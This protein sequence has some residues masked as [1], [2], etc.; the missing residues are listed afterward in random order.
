MGFL[1]VKTGSNLLGIES[2]VAWA[3]IG[4]FTTDNNYPCGEAGEGCGGDGSGG[5]GPHRTQYYVDPSTN[6]EAVQRKLK[7]GGHIMV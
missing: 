3:S 7:E 6:V 5:D 2:T 1:R 4:Q